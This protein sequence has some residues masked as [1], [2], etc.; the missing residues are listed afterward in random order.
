MCFVGQKTRCFL[1]REDKPSGRRP[2]RLDQRRGRTLHS[3]VFAACDADSKPLHQARKLHCET[4][5]APVMD[6]VVRAIEERL[7]RRCVH[8]GA[9][10]SQRCFAAA[11]RTVDCRGRPSDALLVLTL[12][13]QTWGT[14]LAALQ[15]YWAAAEALGYDRVVYGD[16]L[17]PWTYDG[18]TMLGA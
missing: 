13:V 8:R 16:G 17:W 11:A 6:Y 14:D 2:V 15:R 1:S 10:K 4:A 7:A 9:S 3:T 5:E 18:W 12:G